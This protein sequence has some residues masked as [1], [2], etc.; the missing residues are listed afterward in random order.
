MRHWLS[1]AAAVV[2]ALAGFARPIAAPTVDEIVARHLEARGGAER[3]KA[4]QTIKFTRKVAT[5]FNT[6]DVIILK[7]RPQLF[8]AES[9]PPG[10]PMT[11]RGVNPEGAWDTAQGGKIVMR[12]ADAAAETRELDADFDGPLVNW[13]AKGHTVTYEG[14]ESLP[15]GDAHKLKIVTRSG[16]VRTIYLDAQTY[17]DRR[18][19]GVLNLPGGRRFD[20]S[21]DFGDWQEVGGVKFPFDISEER[22]GKEPVQSL[23]TYTVKIEVNVPMDDALFATPKG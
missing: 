15:G 20:V 17:L 10:G 22:T 13:K 9:A 11:V 16:I 2:C 4:I 5:Q 21:I 6:V 1:T 7:K 3:L 18:H 12:S 14:T 8:R 19:T 23:A